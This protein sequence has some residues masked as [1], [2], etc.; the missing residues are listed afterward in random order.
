MYA[1]KMLT[2]QKTFQLQIHYGNCAQNMF[3]QRREVNITLLQYATGLIFFL[4]N[5]AN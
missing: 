4:L 2:M 5:E 1:F 3:Q